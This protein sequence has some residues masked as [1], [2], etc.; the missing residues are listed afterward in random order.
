[1]LYNVALASGDGKFVDR[2]FGRCDKFFIAEIDTETQEIR[3]LE[4]RFAEPLCGG[5]HN[6]EDLEAVYEL[7]SD[8]KFVIASRAGLAVKELFYAKGLIILEDASAVEDAL[9]KLIRHIGIAEKGQG[10]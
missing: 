4:P 2:H 3:Y 10:I 1:M 9:K 8:C 5:G 7:L 6:E